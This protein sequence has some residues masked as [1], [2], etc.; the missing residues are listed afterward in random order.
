MQRW[1]Q[2]SGK[3]YPSA[4]RQSLLIFCGG[5]GLPKNRVLYASNCSRV[6]WQS[7]YIVWAK[8][9]LLNTRVVGALV[10]AAT[11]H[12][13]AV[14]DSYSSSDSSSSLST[15]YSATSSMPRSVH[16]RA[17]SAKIAVRRSPTPRPGADCCR[18]G[19]DRPPSSY[20]SLDCLACLDCRD[21]RDSSSKAFHC[22]FL[23]LP[24]PGITP[25]TR[26][27]W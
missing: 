25:D 26:F 16:D 1:I 4:T 23:C 5:T 22:I 27:C 17:T 19:C 12:V 21:C 3:S 24:A 20:Q 10:G 2:G 9:A 8:S 7:L 11:E 18:H 14:A 15:E 6:M 13:P